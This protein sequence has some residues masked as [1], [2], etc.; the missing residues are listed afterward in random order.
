MNTCNSCSPKS[1]RDVGSVFENYVARRMKENGAVILEMNY[2]ARRGEID[3][4]ALKGGTV[5]F[6][7]VKSEKILDPADKMPEWRIDRRKAEALYTAARAYTMKLRAE[8]IDP[9]ELKFRFDAASVLFDDSLRPVK[10]RYY[11]NFLI[12]NDEIAIL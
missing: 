1:S 4:I 12:L 2:A 7:E 9:E 3:I 10:F 11:E 8:G 6:V 5:I